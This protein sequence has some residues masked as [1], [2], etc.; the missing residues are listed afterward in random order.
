MDDNSK[1]EAVL[2]KMVKEKKLDKN[3]ILS[4]LK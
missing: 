2:D 4:K 3:M 1:F